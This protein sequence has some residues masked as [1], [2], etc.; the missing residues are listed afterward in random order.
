[1]I[2]L[3]S[4]PINNLQCAPAASQSKSSSIGIPN[5]VGTYIKGARKTLR[6][7]VDTENGKAQ[8]YYDGHLIAINDNDCIRLTDGHNGLFNMIAFMSMYQTKADRISSFNGLNVY[9][10]EEPEDT[11][12]HRLS[13][14]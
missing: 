4:D 12:L 8:F 6:A 7:I 9:Q 10:I 1:M 3:N 13:R 14:Y 2:R 5:V 11:A